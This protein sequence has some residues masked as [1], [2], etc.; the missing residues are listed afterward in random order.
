RGHA[1][2]GPSAGAAP[3]WEEGNPVVSPLRKPWLRRAI[4][5][6]VGAVVLVMVGRHVARTWSD[7]HANGRAVRVEPGWIALAGAL[8]LAGLG[9]C[10]VFFGRVLREGPSPVALGPAV[11]A[12]LISHLGKYVPG[13]AMVVV[14]RV[15]L[16]VPHGA[17]PAT[18]AFA[19]L[20]E[21]LVMMASGGLVAALGFATR[22]DAPVLRLALLL[23]L[24][25]GLAF[26]VAV[27]PRV[28]PRL[29]APL[30]L[31]F[32]GV[33]PEA[34]PRLSHGLLARGL[35]WTAP[36]WVL[37]GLSQV[38]I[39]RA[40]RP[41]GVPMGLWPLVVGGVALATVAGFVIAV[42][43]GGLGVR[44][45]VLWNVMAPVL[46]LEVATLSAVLLRLAW[47]GGELLAAAVLAVLRPRPRSSSSSSSSP[48]GSVAP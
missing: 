42:A 44:E 22:A 8:Y 5:A 47:V 20:Y 36:G 19:T 32:P 4:K 34:L 25:L 1:T 37:L 21:T 11:R 12:Y 23:A 3:P 33:G 6:A 26:F 16:V 41:E 10:G 46:G 17:R 7:L 24:G 39:I 28:F 13:K 15:A 35:L 43:P 31:P 29:V 45:W 18:A 48:A 38:A 14:M 9:A 30:R 40:V 27:E 2:S